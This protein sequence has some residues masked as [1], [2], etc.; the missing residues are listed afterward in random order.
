MDERKRMLNDLRTMQEFHDV[1]DDPGK[2]ASHLVAVFMPNPMEI[3]IA[4]QLV[5][6]RDRTKAVYEDKLHEATELLKEAMAD[7]DD[8]ESKLDR[9][10]KWFEG[11]NKLAEEADVTLAPIRGVLS[12][13]G[14]KGDLVV[15]GEAL[16]SV[17]ETYER[18]VAAILMRA[19]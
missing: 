4:R 15:H 10:N 1:E 5:G 16:K 6:M 13:Q 12:A 17:V 2:L 7:V 18:L 9:A 8:K 3:G 19:P 11:V 14:D